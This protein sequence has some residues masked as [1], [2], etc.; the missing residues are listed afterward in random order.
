[1]NRLEELTRG[2]AAAI[3][4]DVSTWPWAQEDLALRGPAT[5][6]HDV[7]FSP[8]KNPADAYTVEDKLRITVVYIM[9]EDQSVTLRVYSP[10]HG[11]GIMQAVKEGATLEARMY[12]ITQY[13][14]LTALMES[15]NG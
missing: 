11:G 9:H 6:Y 8:L 5:Q 3:G 14:A 12:A 2:A 15:D 7:N 4:L 13:A 10:S 1:M